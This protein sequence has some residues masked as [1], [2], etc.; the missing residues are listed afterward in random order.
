M[1]S[2][3]HSI[4]IKTWPRSQYFYYFT[5]MLPTGFNLNVE[6]DVTTTYK[7]LKSQGKKFFPAYLY[8]TTKLINKEQNFRVAYQDKQLGYYEELNPSYTCFH[9]DD[10]TMSNMWTVYDED[11]NIFYNNYIKDQ[12]QYGQNHGIL[13]KPEVPP[14]NSYMVGVIPW[15]SFKSYSPVPFG[16]GESTNFF[17]ILEAGKFYEKDNR[18]LMPL[19]MTVHHAIADGY[20]V[21]SFFNELQAEMNHPKNWMIS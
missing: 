5:K 13:A 1:N 14:A 11:F 15:L 19:S 12:K 10:Q 6:I 3:F 18:L 16:F 4:D 9:E 7:M 2:N 20:Q 8:L 17:P 21:S